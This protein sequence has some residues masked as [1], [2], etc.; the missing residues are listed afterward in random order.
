MLPAPPQKSLLAE[1]SRRVLLTAAAATGSM[2]NEQTANFL[3]HAN[4]WPFSPTWLHRFPTASSVTQL[5]YQD[6]ALRSRLQR[7]W[8]VS[9]E[10]DWFYWKPRKPNAQSQQ[11]FKLYVSVHPEVIYPAFSTTVNILSD[12]ETHT[13]KTSCHPRGLLRPDR[14]VIYAETYEAIDILG[15]ALVRALAGIR[16]QGVPFTASFSESDFLSWG[17]D[18]PMSVRH[19]GGSWRRWVTKKLAG[20]LHTSD[21][22]T[23]EGRVKFALDC[24]TR[25]GVDTIKWTPSN[26]LWKFQL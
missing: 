25:E 18:P 11:R 19:F 9:E 21:S 17:C 6:E 5:L 1:L 12:I 4:W 24:I 8:I 13:F 22:A 15:T 3:Y 20:Y 10:V 14:M 16:A 26:G 23:A 2:N 7:F